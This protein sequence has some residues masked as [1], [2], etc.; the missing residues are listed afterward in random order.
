MPFG[1]RRNMKSRSRWELV[2][3]HRDSKATSDG[4]SVDPKPCDVSELERLA[5]EAIDRGDPFLI[6]RQLGATDVNYPT[7]ARRLLEALV[8]PFVRFAEAIELRSRRHL[9]CS[10][11]RRLWQAAIAVALTPLVLRLP[12]DP[13]GQ[14]GKGDGR[15]DRGAGQ[16]RVRVWA[17][18]LV[19]DLR[20]LVS[21]EEATASASQSPPERPD[22]EL[23][24]H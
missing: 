9:T 12:V 22:D 1:G 18:T 17:Y 13:G 15:V 11:D 21:R 4:G 8:G 6:L 5:E 24:F 10:E 7:L 16:P 2:A 23:F 14:D 19:I 20:S 3:Q